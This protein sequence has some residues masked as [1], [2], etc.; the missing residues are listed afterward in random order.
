MIPTKAF[1]GLW[2]TSY[3][4]P[5]HKRIYKHHF[6]NCG[7]IS[8]TPEEFEKLLLKSMVEKPKQYGFQ[9]RLS[10]VWPLSEILKYF[11]RDERHVCILFNYDCEKTFVRF[12]H[13]LLLNGLEKTVLIPILLF[14]SELPSFNFSGC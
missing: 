8:L 12:L 9:S 2:K 4:E 6:F 11:Y 7:R 1:I 3:V 14:F 5:V 10:N 13:T